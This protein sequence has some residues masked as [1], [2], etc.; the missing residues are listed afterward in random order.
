MKKLTLILLSIL[1]V[2]AAK[3]QESPAAYLPKLDGTIKARTEISAYDGYY[4]IN[5]RNARLGA[6]GNITDES[7]YRIQVDFS[8]EGSISFL[9]AYAGYRFGRLDF[10]LGQQQ[11]HFSTDMDRGPAAALFANR[12]F[13]SKFITSYYGHTAGGSYIRQIGSRDLGAFASYNLHQG[14][15]LKLSL[16]LFSGNGIN[17]PKWNNTVNILGRVSVKPSANTRLSLSYYN[18]YTPLHEEGISMVARRITMAGA[19]AG[20]SD[21]K[22]LAEMELANRYLKNAAGGREH[23]TLGLVQAQYRLELNQSCKA[24]YWAPAIRWDTGNNLDYID[25]AA[26][27]RTN[28]DLNRLTAGVRLG[29]EGKAGRSHIGLNYEK[30]FFKNTP[31]DISVNRLFQDKLTLE[32]VASF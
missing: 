31:S 8:N 21:G 28:L 26:S 13:I 14:S 3:A 22:L 19:E 7:F 17:N 11:L 15:G 32:F 24:S 6:S 30:Y 9:D 20:Y 4:R 18:G 10:I 29:F 12:S 25:K 23:L 27:A 1:A 5:V 2:Q 16:G